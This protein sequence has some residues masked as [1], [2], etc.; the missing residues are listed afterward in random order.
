M[1]KKESNEGKERKKWVMQLG[2]QTFCQMIVRDKWLINGQA[3]GLTMFWLEKS[4]D[5]SKK[6]DAYYNHFL[7]KD[8]FQFDFI[9]Y[10]LTFDSRP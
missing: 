7:Y 1:S 8:A 10:L 9:V 2:Q 3:Y 5:S 4:I 6:C